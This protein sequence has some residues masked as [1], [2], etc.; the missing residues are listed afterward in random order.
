MHREEMAADAG[1]LFV[2]PAAAQ[3]TF[4]MKDTPLS[5]DMIFINRRGVVCSIVSGT[6]PFSTEHIPSGCTAQTVLEVNAGEAAARGI[7]RGAPARHP[8][9]EAPVWPCD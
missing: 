6:T 1:M 7:K 3:V 5:L 2:Y 9:I 4:W 8:A